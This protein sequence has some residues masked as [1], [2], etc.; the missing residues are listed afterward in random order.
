M[1][2]MGY[3]KKSPERCAEEVRAMHRLGWREFLL[4]DDIF[5]SDRKWAI[6]VAEAIQQTGVDMTWTCNNGIRVLETGNA[7]V[8][9]TFGKGGRASLEQGRLAIKTARANSIES[10]GWFLIGL[11]A[12][13][14]ESMQDTIEYARTV[15]LDILKF[16]SRR[17]AAFARSIGMNITCTALS[18]FMITPTWSMKRSNAI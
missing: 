7:E 3:R 13:T 15:K 16:G 9:K 11:S 1:C 12:D 8:L 10:S 2:F 17:T 18:L 14:E 5:T 4:A 6:Q